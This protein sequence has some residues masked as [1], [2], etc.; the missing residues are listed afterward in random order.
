MIDIIMEFLADMVE[1][2]LGWLPESP[3]HDIVS[4]GQLSGFSTIMG[5]INYFV[6]IGTILTILTIYLSAVLLWYGVR[7]IMRL[8][9]YID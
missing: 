2:A 1:G 8:A 6:P 5:Y 7:W 9:Q 4:S 3:F